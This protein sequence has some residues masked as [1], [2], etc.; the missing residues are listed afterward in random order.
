MNRLR[1]LLNELEAKFEELRYEID[2]ILTDPYSAF[3][4]PEERKYYKE[5]VDYIGFLI[6]E[7][8]FAVK[9]T[10]YEHYDGGEI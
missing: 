1:E 3:E 4:T 2:G 9:D 8:Y 5:L 7:I 6:D 10:E